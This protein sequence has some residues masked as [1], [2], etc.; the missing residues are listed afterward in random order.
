MRRLKGDKR[1]FRH[2][3][4][5]IFLAILLLQGTDIYG[6]LPINGF[7]AY[8][9]IPVNPS[10]NRLF[11]LDFD[12][13]NQTDFF[14]FNNLTNKSALQKNNVPDDKITSSQ[15]Y[16]PFPITDIKPFIQFK[17]KE[18]L[19]F[20]ISQR[21]RKAALLSITGG[22][23]GVRMQHKFDAYPSG[24][25]VA[26][27]N[28]DGN[29]E[30]VVCGN[31]F[32]G[33]S[34][35]IIKNRLEEIKVISEGVYSSVNFIDLNYDGFPDIAA[36]ESRRNS[37]YFFINDQNGNFRRAR[38]LRFDPSVKSFKT[39]DLNSDGY[40]DLILLRQRGIDVLEG[41]SVSSFKKQHFVRTP[42]PPDEASVDDYNG[43]GIND[44]V[45]MNKT[46]GEFFFQINKGG[47]NYYYPILLLKRSGFAD[48]KSFRD[49]F[50]KKVVLLSSDGELYV[51]SK[52]DS[53]KELEKASAFGSVSAIAAFE[54]PNA[55]HKDL[56]IVD[57]YQKALI[58]LTGEPG[59]S[60]A[61][62]FSVRISASFEKI[63]IYDS[64]K[65]EKIFY[66]HSKGKNLIEIVKYNFERQKIDKSTLYVK[67]DIIDLKLKPAS[68][69]EYPEIYVLSDKSNP[70]YSVYHNTGYKY[71]EI[72]SGSISPGFIDADVSYSD[73]L[74]YFTWK[75]SG[76]GCELYA[77]SFGRQ[78]TEKI[79]YKYDE[80]LQDGFG[81]Y[82]NLLQPSKNE[83]FNFTLIN[84]GK[85]A[86][87]IIYDPKTIRRIN[88]ETAGKNL[89]RFGDESIHVYRS[90]DDRRR[91]LFI[92]DFG[93]SI[94][95]KADLNSKSR[96][97]S[98]R[99]SGKTEN[100]MQYVVDKS[101]GKKFKVI[102]I[103]GSEKCLYFKEIE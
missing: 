19:Y 75:R 73:T 32:K 98:A 52:F 25:A 56:V 53:K 93:N 21:E 76:Y 12:N 90:G 1:D 99:G 11:T 54:E 42:V 13:N 85:E 7:C 102:Y 22:G 14:L 38:N 95:Y 97:I 45:Y 57:N 70:K 43:D 71:S 8:R 88:F 77:G 4:T 82:S 61:R 84:N 68:E 23:I 35:F 48:M 3:R 83:L 62:Y 33:I 72:K 60:I 64:G 36:W 34:L 59:N 86:E 65:N 31:N 79:L 51:I 41:D 26:D 96:I 24:L 80:K 103:G 27:V 66:L 16:A 18:L 29:S 6:Q 47:G 91:I 40:M 87:G 20:A 37:I 10:Y 46:S 55:P 44:L 101:A 39:A 100:V 5:I 15:R 69:Y 17:R 58:I 67:G 78:G 74:S 92:Y 28:G 2:G 9:K 50:L 30:A 94:F 49:S 89:P 63:N 81:L